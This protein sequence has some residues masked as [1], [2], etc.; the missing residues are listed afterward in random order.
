MMDVIIVLFHR[1]GDCGWI[2]DKINTKMIR[3]GLV[4]RVSSEMCGGLV[5]LVGGDVWRWGGLVWFGFEG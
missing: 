5:D 1:R 3:V 4:L 2:D